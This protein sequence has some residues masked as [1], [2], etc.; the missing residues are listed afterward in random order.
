MADSPNPISPRVSIALSAT[1]WGAVIGIFFVMTAAVA[2]FARNSIVAT[3]AIGVMFVAALAI[4]VVLH[5]SSELRLS[6]RKYP[7]D[8]SHDTTR[9]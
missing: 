8:H 2:I 7:R 5:L 9:R 4:L 1:G 3:I 6:L